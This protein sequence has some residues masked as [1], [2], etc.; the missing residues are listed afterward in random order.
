MLSSTEVIN[1]SRKKRFCGWNLGL[2]GFSV[3][4]ES[5]QM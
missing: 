1:Y 4:C 2:V 3:G 5:G